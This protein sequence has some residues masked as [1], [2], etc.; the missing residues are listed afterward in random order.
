MAETAARGLP[1]GSPFALDDDPAY[2]RWRAWKLD[3]APRRSED[4]LVPIGDLA[5]PT[6][7]ELSA[8]TDTL[9]RANMAIYAS[10]AAQGSEDKRLPMAIGA[11][12]GLSR[13]DA[14]WLADEDGISS[15]TPAAAGDGAPR[16]DF[17]PYTKQPIRWH[18]DGYYNPPE[19]TIRAMILH[20]VRPASEGGANALLDHEI[21]YILLRDENPDWVRAL[22]APDA[23]TIPA[24]HDAGGEARPAQSGPVF[25]VDAE[26]GDLHMR[27]T[28]RTRSIAWKD[29]VTTSAAVARLA[30]LL[31]GD[32]RSLP[33]VF[34]VR[35]ESGMGLVC[36]NVL[37][38][39]SAFAEVPGAPRRLL[40]RARY[41]DRI[42]PTAGAW[43][44]DPE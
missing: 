14:N 34:R 33:N 28:A 10:P 25:S 31:D 13:L 18:T 1:P 6:A 23:M 22:S 5:A 32:A 35:Q 42:A 29:D 21:A 9:R 27:Y 16:P 17:I 3:C 39:R 12:L 41:Y 26:T 19:R 40:F 37:H 4:L 30:A 2:R 7:A 11:R 38:D 44:I 36:N 24:R 43:R 15:I 20:C 8:L